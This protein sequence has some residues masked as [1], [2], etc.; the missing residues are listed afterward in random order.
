MSSQ[1]KCFYSNLHDG[2]LYINIINKHIKLEVKDGIAVVNT[3]NKEVNKE[4]VSVMNQVLQ[5]KTVKG[6]VLMSGKPGCFI[7]G[8]DIGMLEACKTAEEV[9]EIARGGQEIFQRIEDSNKPVVAA[10]MGSCLGG[11]C[12]TALAC[13]YRI[14]VDDKNTTLSQPEVL[15]GLLPGAGGTQR[16]PKMVGAANALPLLLTGKNLR[17]SKAKKMGIV[18]QKK[19]F[20]SSNTF[21]DDI[22]E[23]HVLGKNISTVWLILGLYSCILKMLAEAAVDFIKKNTE[24]FFIKYLFDDI[25]D[26]HVLRKYFKSVVYSWII[27]MHLHN[28]LIN[29]RNFLSSFAFRHIFTILLLE[30]KGLADGSL[31]KTPRKKNLQE[32]VF[33]YIFGYKFVRNYIFKTAKATV[34]K[35]T[36]GLFPAPLKI[37]EVVRTGVEKGPEAGYAHEREAFGELAM[38]KESKALIG[39]FHGRT[40]CKKNSYGTPE[41][42]AEKLAVLGAGLMGA[43][44]AQVSIARGLDTI[45][46]DISQEGVSRGQEQVY[47]G[48]ALDAKKKKITTFERDT[49][50]SKLVPTLNYENFDQV[51]MVIEAVFED[52]V[53]FVLYIRE[54]CIFASNTSALPISKIA[55]ASKRPEK[56]IGMHYFSPV[57]KMELLEIITTDKTSKDT[58]ASAVD[59]GLRQGKSVIVVKDGPGFYTTREQLDPANLNKLS[60]SF[61]FPIGISTLADEVGIDVA[62]HVAEDL[63][64]IFGERF[65]GGNINVL[66]DMVAAGFLGRK[67]GKGIFE[68]QPGVKSRPLNE[69]GLKILKKYHVPAPAGL[70]YKIISSFRITDEDCQY[71]LISRLVNESV[72]CLQEGILSSP[73]E[74]DIGAVFGIGFPAHLG[75]PFRYLDLY[76]AK[77]LVDRML[78][79]QQLYGNQFTPCQLLLDHANDSSKRFHK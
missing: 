40:A 51:D 65:Q 3:L 7:A 78:R 55:E 27:F 42:K 77:Q 61:G 31:K 59:V 1:S 58:I 49:I 71:R 14:A 34:M 72:M 26:T 53:Y 76:G 79:Y 68:Y 41:K 50:Y 16:L 13:Q 62:T 9:T 11:G 38:T 15:L 8:A 5:D 37:I 56:V 44:I 70:A 66:K 2:Y 12:E 43:G 10:I 22:C 35:Q 45:M 75:G 23:T 69:E 17:A 25:C 63:G 39:L 28:I 48:L 73:L 20:S 6:V 74:G 54:D 64:K 24:F 19:N 67:S 33:D 47:K 60:T 52:I 21:L 29:L 30:K 36:K 57:D 4:V 32:K 46:K 18:D